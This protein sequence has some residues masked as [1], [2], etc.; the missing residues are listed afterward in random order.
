MIQLSFR[1]IFSFRFPVSFADELTNVL[2]FYD[3]YVICEPV[4]L[5]SVLLS[6]FSEKNVLYTY[7]VFWILVILFIELLV[8]IEFNEAILYYAETPLDQ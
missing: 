5:I 2:C 6:A 1:Q 7:K 4:I 8:G 3:F